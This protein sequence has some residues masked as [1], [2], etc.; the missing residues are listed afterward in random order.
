MAYPHERP[1]S[2]PRRGRQTYARKKQR[3]SRYF[4]GYRTFCTSATG[5]LPN[6]FNFMRYFF[7][8]S[9]GITVESGGGVCYTI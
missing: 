3:Q 7:D 2:R 5:I 1:Y 6:I 8:F 9:V 4:S